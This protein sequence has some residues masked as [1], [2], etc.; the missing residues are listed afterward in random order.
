M[1]SVGGAEPVPNKQVRVFYA[2]KFK[3]PLHY[4]LFLSIIFA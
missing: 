2:I 4:L 3:Y 1:Y